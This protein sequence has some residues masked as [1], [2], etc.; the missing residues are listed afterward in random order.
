VIG[1]IAL[2]VFADIVDVR[3]CGDPNGEACSAGSFIASL[4]GPIR[5]GIIEI[6]VYGRCYSY[7]CLAASLKAP[8]AAPIVAEASQITVHRNVDGYASVSALLISPIAFPS[9]PIGGVR[10]KCVRRHLHGDARLV[11]QSITAI[12]LPTPRLEQRV[13]RIGVRRHLDSDARLFDLPEIPVAFP[14]ESVGRIDGMCVRRHLDG[15]ACPGD[16][17]ITVIALPSSSVEVRMRIRGGRGCAALGKCDP[18]ACCQNNGEQQRTNRH[19]TPY[20][21]ISQSCLL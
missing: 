13:Y 5:S 12:A 3:V 7:T 17:P 10:G 2:P 8:L 15:S 18:R 9:A 20:L 11:E 14:T 16:L 19:G 21:H 1:L 6:A 4:A